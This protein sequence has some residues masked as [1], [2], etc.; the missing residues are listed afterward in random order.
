MPLSDE[1]L[2]I[3]FQKLSLVRDYSGKHN[4]K[5]KKKKKKKDWLCRILGEHLIPKP[6]ETYRENMHMRGF[7][8]RTADSMSPKSERGQARTRRSSSDT[9]QHALLCL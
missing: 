2:T 1:N 6:Y 7:Q 3:T 9:H 5:K 8:Q 4:L